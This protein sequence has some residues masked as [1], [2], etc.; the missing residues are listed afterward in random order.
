MPGFEGMVV[1]PPIE[2]GSG[3]FDTKPV[4]V[5]LQ[6]GVELPLDK[7]PA[8]V[9]QKPFSK[10][11]VLL[12]ERIE[13][14][15]P[16]ER[17][18][19]VVHMRDP[20][21]LKQ[22][23]RFGP[24]DRGT[25]EFESVQIKRERYISKLQVDRDRQAAE[26]V[27]WLS[28]RIKLEVIHVP[29][30]ASTPV[31]NIRLADVEGLTK[32]DDVISVSLNEG[33]LELFDVLGHHADPNDDIL[34]VRQAIRTD[35][36]DNL[37]NNWGYIGV[38]DSGK[39]ITHDMLNDDPGAFAG[40]CNQGGDTCWGDGGP[41]NGLAGP[42]FP[43]YDIAD[44]G[45]HGTP[46]LGGISGSSDLGAELRGITRITTDHWRGAKNAT[47]GS[48]ANVAV[49]R[50]IQNA[51]LYG[52]DVISNSYSGW[53]G[54]GGGSAVAQLF[55][56]AYDLGLA[57]I[58]SNG[59]AACKAKKTPNYRLVTR[60]PKNDDSQRWILTDL[61]GNT[62]TIQQ[63][64]N[65]RFLDAYL[66][67]GQDFSVVTRPAQGDDTQIWILTDG[68]D[69]TY[70]IKQKSNNRFLD[71][72]L[73]DGQD[74]SVVTRSQQK[75]PAQ[76]W[77]LTDLG[78][79]TY[80][81][82]QKSNNRYMDAHE[83]SAQDFSVVTRPMQGNDTQRW[84]LTPLGGGT[85][86]IQQKSNN[87]FLDA[88]GVPGTPKSTAEDWAVVTRTAQGNDTQ[89]WIINAGGGD[90]YTIKQ[91][92]N[93]RLLEAFQEEGTFSDGRCND[94]VIRT[95]AI[96]KDDNNEQ[97]YE[98]A[99]GSVGNGPSAHKV[100]GVG[101]H[102]IDPPCQS[103]GISSDVCAYSSRGPTTDGRYKPDIL[104]YTNYES[105]SSKTDVKT[106]NMGG[107]SGAAPTVAA[108]AMLYNNYFEHHS[109]SAT[110]LAPGHI[111]A[112]LIA[113]GEH[114]TKWEG[115]YTNVGVEPDIAHLN[116]EGA[117][118]PKMALG[119]GSVGTVTLSDDGDLATIDLD[120]SEGA[121]GIKAGIWWPEGA[122]ETHDDVDLI[123]RNPWNDTIARAE[124]GNSVWER[125]SVDGG[126]SG[127]AGG[128][129]EVQ[130][131]GYDVNNEQQ[132]YYYVE[133]ALNHCWG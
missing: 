89:R 67:D 105:S 31:V 51:L 70:T 57:V 66:S 108:M 88:Y 81:I 5:T 11:S 100:I 99:F 21:E 16:D 130:I 61:G 102:E 91:K 54:R 43:N 79:D 87:R 71:A 83:T 131:L 112:A 94:P 53:G 30:L 2:G 63:K 125:A 8:L 29:W 46:I 78:G 36:Y 44:P 104:G 64:S 50:A 38:I 103:G 85:Y 95:G 114:T 86:T 110:W 118:R 28:G 39:R 116:I 122:E 117:G 17:E 42:A 115:S 106:K 52:D 41:P 72:Y 34:D 75:N 84:I 121:C 1:I 6:T 3:K 132:V 48:I 107:T 76:R 55:D 4:Q 127:L 15:K 40:D 23:P 26:F 82:Q 126:N 90:T 74:F 14:A 124:S 45:N 77:I 59:N 60:D 128:R 69:G 73:S 12:Q 9:V 47:P 65:N 32:F 33:E 109:D 20:L 80:T 25:K 24:E 56:N 129:Y 10:I 13:N 49:G 7:G 96:S 58:V 119:R 37:G 62:Y 18:A 111:Y 68:G 27:N 113:S 133:T 22:M 98:P 101:A 19:V 93:N 97:L 120:V 92:S 123:I 35:F